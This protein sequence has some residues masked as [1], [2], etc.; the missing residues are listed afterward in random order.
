MA[1]ALIDCGATAL[2][3]LKRLNLSVNDIETIF[4]TH[5]HG[6]HFGGLVWLLLDAVYGQPRIKPLTVFGPPTIEARLN[7]AIDALYPGAL[8]APPAFAL[9]FV[10][11]RPG[12][13]FKHGGY[14]AEVMTVDHPSGAPSYGVRVNAK[15]R[16]LAFT[17]DTAW[18]KSVIELGRGADVYVMDCWKRHGAPAVHISFDQIMEHLPALDAR[19]IV[20]THMDED[21]LAFAQTI[22]DARLIPASDGLALDV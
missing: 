14:E 11:V 9:K 10:E 3:G 4:I 13:P 22:R 8:S 17:G 6:D 7:R 16:T 20:L 12:H 15:G 2:I 5:L 1:P 19:R 21:M 18:T